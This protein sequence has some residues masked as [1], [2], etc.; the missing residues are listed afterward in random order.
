MIKN[1][2]QLSG[3]Q[4]KSISML[5]GGIGKSQVAE[6]LNITRKTLS[7]WL[8]NENFVAVLTQQKM[9]AL[10]TTANMMVDDQVQ[11]RK[12][13]Q[14]SIL[15]NVE[16]M[17]AT[18]SIKSTTNDHKN[19]SEVLDKALI[20]LGLVDRY[21]SSLSVSYKKQVTPISPEVAEEAERVRAEREARNE[22]VE[23]DKRLLAIVNAPTQD[24][25]PKAKMTK[26]Q[27]QAAFEKMMET[28][29]E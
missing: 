8:Q 17:M 24:D 25:E 27:K 5:V 7:M 14:S 11:Q 9:V 22:Q 21:N 10:T 4:L 26:K 3:A 12:L 1:V 18:L 15:T 16:T 13:I 23:L 20:S 6:V 19:V 29:S 2:K 28:I